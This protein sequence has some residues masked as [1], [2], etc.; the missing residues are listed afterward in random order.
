MRLPRTSTRH[1]GGFTLIELLVVI[2]II[3]LLAGLL[4]GASVA[5]LRKMDEVKTRNEISGL[6]NSV[7]QFESD[8]RVNVPPPS[9]IWIDESGQYATPP[10]GYTAAQVTQLAIDSQA[11]LRKVW[12]NIDLRQNGNGIDWNSNGVPN[13]SYV[14]EGE[15]CLVLFL[16]GAR[17]NGNYV[18]FSG[19]N[20]TNPMDTTSTKRFGPYFQFDTNRFGQRGNE[21]VGVPDRSSVPVYLDPWGTY[22]A[23]FSS[24]KAANGYNASATAG[25]GSDCSLITNGAYTSSTQAP[26]Q[27]YNPDTF[28][29]I[30]AGRN[31]AF[32]PGGTWQAANATNIGAAGADDLTNF[33]N[34]KLGV[35]P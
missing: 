15:Q 7:K 20:S 6:A 5:V 12:P 16:G 28:Q 35:M 27:Y 26:F 30:S 13:E 19:T 34:N 21:S 14:L 22:Y 10:Q 24:G 2:S 23:Y 31:Q 3:A 29:I 33:Y 32:G 9:R 25:L 11:Y 4:T 18:G 1:R 8:F 17:V